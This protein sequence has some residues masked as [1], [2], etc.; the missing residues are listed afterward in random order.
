MLIRVDSCDY[1]VVREPSIVDI[2]SRRCIYIVFA[3]RFQ[4]QTQSNSISLLSFTKTNCVVDF[5]YFAPTFVFSQCRVTHFTVIYCR[6][7][8]RQDTTTAAVCIQTLYIHLNS[9]SSP[10]SS[11]SLTLCIY[12]GLHV[13]SFGIHCAHKVF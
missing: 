3:E 2:V 7:V 13:K 10:T 1:E 12:R 11:P 4:T 5:V 8:P 9:A 6:S